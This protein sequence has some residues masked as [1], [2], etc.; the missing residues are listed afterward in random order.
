MTIRVL[1]VDDQDLVRA[2]FAMV[3]G[4]QPDLSVVGEAADGAAAIRL[5]REVP[6]DVMVMDVR[7]QA[8]TAWPPPAR[9]DRRPNG[10]GSSSSPRSTW[11]STRSLPCAPAPAGSC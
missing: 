8:W 10:P 2:G 4:S 9:S 3:L 11:T 5:A 7:M 1:L 6:A